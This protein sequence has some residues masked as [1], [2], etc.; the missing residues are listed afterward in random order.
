MVLLAAAMAMGPDQ[1]DQGWIEK[2]TDPTIRAGV[3]SAVNENL[4]PA[5]TE[6]VYPGHFTI[7]ADGRG[8][9]SDTTWPGLDSWQMAGAYLLMGKTRLVKD[10]FDFVRAAQR[11][12]GNIPFAIFSGDTRPDNSYLRGMK[13]PDDSFKYTPP[14]REGLPESSRRTREWVGLFKHWELETNPLANLGPICYV[15]TAAEIYQSTADRDW[16]K[17][18]LPSVE[19][20]GKYLVTQI[21]SNGLVGGSGFYTERPPRNGWDGVTQCYAVQ[22]FRD[23]EML[24]RASHRSNQAN[25][26][27]AQADKLTKSFNAAFWL[28]DHFAEYIHPTHG[29]VDIHGL[30][31][32]NWAAIGFGLA[33]KQQTR[34]LWPQLTGTKAFWPGGMPTLTVTKPFSYQSWEHEQVPF[35]AVDV[36]N[37]VASMGRSWYL[38]ALACKRMKDGKRLIE[39]ARL[40]SKAAEGGFWRER[41]HPQP[42]GT[43]RPGG[44]QKYCE[45]PAVLIRVVL[46]NR[47]I[48]LKVDRHS[49]RQASEPGTQENG[50]GATPKGAASPS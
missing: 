16:L 5:A 24:E 12:D 26:W 10:Y 22:A 4:L 19:A 27:K 32:T 40:V 47:A 43:V 46:E 37:D 21:S 45:Y 18:H 33:S 8:Y 23:L 35:E 13:W 1:I 17:D 28:H 2:V 6:K 15:L 29:A 38:E 11:K 36:T 9:G 41:Y 14:V 30:S 20:T 3:N 42:D 48:F 49:G 39:S 34:I 44:S 25:E 7:N 50:V 31:D